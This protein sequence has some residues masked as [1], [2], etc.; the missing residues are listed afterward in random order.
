M[1][2]HYRDGPHMMHLD[3]GVCDCDWRTR[4]PQSGTPKG[5]TKAEIGEIKKITRRVNHG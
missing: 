1:I 2:V 4:Y 5:W 3:G